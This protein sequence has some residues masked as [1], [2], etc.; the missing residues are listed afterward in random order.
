MLTTQDRTPPENAGIFAKKIG[1][2]SPYT[3]RPHLISHHPTSFLRT[4]QTLSAGNH[5]SITWRITCSNSWNRR[6]HPATSL[7]G[8]VSALNGETRMGFSE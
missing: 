8:R 2:A 6:G 1:C 7:R 3:H 4:Y 5:F